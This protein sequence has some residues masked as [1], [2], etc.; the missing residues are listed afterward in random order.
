[1]RR[2]GGA[3]GGKA[4]RVRLLQIVGFRVAGESVLLEEKNATPVLL[5]PEAKCSFEPVRSQEEPTAARVEAPPVCLEPMA[6]LSAR[7]IRFRQA[8]PLPS[9]TTILGLQ[10]RLGRVYR[11]Q[12][13]MNASPGRTPVRPPAQNRYLREIHTGDCPLSAG[14]PPN[15]R[16]M[17]KANERLSRP[18]PRD[19]VASARRSWPT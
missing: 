2:E 13:S 15:V 8:Q 7:S 9:L 17:S 3:V 11:S 4:Y 12:N 18:N 1:M 5:T 6:M 16:A 19:A 14:I 10:S